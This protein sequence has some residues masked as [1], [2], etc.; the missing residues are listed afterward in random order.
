MELTDV[1]YIAAAYADAMIEELDPVSV[2]DAYFRSGSP[3][4]F[5]YRVQALV[6]LQ[7]TLRNYYDKT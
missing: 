2:H 6:H 7:D 3:C 4:E 1:D 5:F